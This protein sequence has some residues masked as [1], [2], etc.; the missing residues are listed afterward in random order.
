[1]FQG[2]EFGNVTYKK[3]TYDADLVVDTKGNAR[4]RDQTLP[5]QRFGTGHFI[6]ADEL[7][8]II[9]DDCDVFV[10]G[11]GQD[12]VAQLTP[13]AKEFLK[14]KKIETRVAISPDAIR[15]YN[16]IAQKKKTIALIHVTC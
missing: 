8:A 10:F 1:M 4:L 15:I 14:K 6:C 3:K 2:T 9:T 12:G 5:R 7:K 16:E 11:S 13:D